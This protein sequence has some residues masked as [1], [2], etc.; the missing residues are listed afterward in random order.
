MTD[1]SRIPFNR[2][3]I[4]GNE[5]AYVRDAVTKGQLAARGFYSER[6]CEWIESRTGCKK[7]LLVHS[8]T[9]ALEMAAI[10]CG[11]QPGDEVI[12]PSFTFVS[13]ANAF[14]LR[15]ASL[16]F[17]DIEPVYKNID[18]SLIERAIT[19]K[20]K[21][22][23]AV[24]YAGVAC[25]MDPIMDLATTNGLRVVEDAAQGILSEYKGRS[26]GAIG[27]I[28]CLSF[29][30]T[31]NV[32]S[33]EGGAILV[34]DEALLERAEVVLEKGTNRS[35]FFQ[36]SVDKYTWVDYGSSYA[37]SEL[38]AAFLLAQ[39]EK[40]DE[41]TQKRLRVCSIYHELLKPLVEAEI[42]ETP[43]VPSTAKQNGHMFYIMVESNAVRRRLI[44]HLARKNI[45]AVFHYVPLHSSPMGQRLSE[46][47]VAL[48]ITDSV[49]ARLLRLPCFFDLSEADVQRVAG[50]IIEFFA[51]GRSRN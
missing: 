20:T 40:A 11:V 49:S 37:A 38:T 32:I 10:L 42:I 6:C 44:E 46:P 47:D 3:S 18:P 15:G 2:P 12:L 36:G 23:V 5:L 22:I 17:V 31:K 28:G 45:L 48:P 50:A 14:A 33:G 30:E 4:V 25:A 7:S 29:H 35:A 1:R 19:E 13:T 27:D 16:V 51:D 41:I 21:V 8:G 9:A 34:N 26:L 39:L 43:Q 24:H